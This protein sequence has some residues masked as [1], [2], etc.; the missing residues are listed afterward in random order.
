[1]LKRINCRQ[2]YY[3]VANVIV[4]IAF[5]CT[6][7]ATLSSVADVLF[8]SGEEAKTLLIEAKRSLI[9]N[10]VFSVLCVAIFFWHRVQ[11]RKEIE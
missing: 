7:Y 5:M 10:G 11:A 6:F 4:L 3:S 9:K 8:V 2:F 1:M